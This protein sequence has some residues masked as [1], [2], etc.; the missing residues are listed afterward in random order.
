MGERDTRKREPAKG[1]AG[2]SALNPIN[3]VPGVKGGTPA[4][5]LADV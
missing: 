4:L 2:D 1:R 5:P 3:M